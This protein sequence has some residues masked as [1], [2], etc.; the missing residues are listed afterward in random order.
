M[1]PLQPP[2]SPPPPSWRWQKRG[3]ISVGLAFLL[4]IVAAATVEVEGAN[5]LTLIILAAGGVLFIA[6]FI[7]AAIGPRADKK[8]KDAE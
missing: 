1:Q 3:I 8:G 4:I 2:K 7:L 6:G 5:V